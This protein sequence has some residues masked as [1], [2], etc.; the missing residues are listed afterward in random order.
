M[1]TKTDAAPK[2]VTTGQMLEIILQQLTPE[3]RAV[4]KWNISSPERVRRLA[5]EA[6]VLDGDS[7]ELL[8]A[9]VSP[10]YVLAFR[11]RPEEFDLIDLMNKRALN[12]EEFP[13][14]ADPRAVGRAPAEPVNGHAPRRK[15]EPKPKSDKASK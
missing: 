11:E 3:E 8:V 14:P 2:P 12:W 15:R 6:V 7:E 13:P 4:V 1:A 10:N 5:E 9:D